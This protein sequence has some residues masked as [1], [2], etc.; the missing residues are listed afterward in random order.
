MGKQVAFAATGQDLKPVFERILAEGWHIW[1]YTEEL[2]DLTDV[3]DAYNKN[4]LWIVHCESVLNIKYGRIDGY[5]SDAVEMSRSLRLEGGW[6]FEHIPAYMQ[7]R[8]YL[9]SFRFGQYGEDQP[10]F[11]TE[12]YYKIV[13][14]IKKNAVD[15]YKIPGSTVWLYPEAKSII[16]EENLKIV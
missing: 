14:M 7:G 13:R 8:I 9:D 15:K 3:I 5:R 16:E 10:V 6:G 11:M 12:M 2:A 4:R 1:S